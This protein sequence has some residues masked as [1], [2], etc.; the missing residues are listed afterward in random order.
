VNWYKWIF[1]NFD[2]NQYLEIVDLTIL[3]EELLTDAEIIWLV[4]EKCDKIKLNNKINQNCYI[5]SINEAFNSL[6]I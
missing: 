1:K 5:V 4:L 2:I 3:T 6:K